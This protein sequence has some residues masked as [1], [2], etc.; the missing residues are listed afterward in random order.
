[1]ENVVSYGFT[2]FAVLCG[3]IG[4]V[5]IWR[6]AAAVRGSRRLA[7]DGVATT[8][9]V[10][11]NQIESY[12][13]GDHGQRLAFRPAVRFRTGTGEEIVAVSSRPGR[14]SGV[15]GMRVDLRYDPDRPTDI[16]ILGGGLRGAGGAGAIVVGMIAIAMG[17]GAYFIGHAMVDA[18]SCV[19]VTADCDSG[20]VP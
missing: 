9:T 19:S 15:V 13:S 12:A 17:L 2:G 10:I 16:E 7:A 8:G 1:M 6:G 11:D 18:A 5:A 20:L 14:R 4:A 3:V